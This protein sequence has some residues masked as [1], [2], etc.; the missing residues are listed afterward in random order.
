M[1]LKEII[2]EHL[3]LVD[4]DYKP[5]ISFIEQDSNTRDFYYRLASNEIPCTL[6]SYLTSKG[7]LYKIIHG[8]VKG[9][10]NAHN[11]LTISNMGSLTRRIVQAIK[12]EE[13]NI[14]NS[15]K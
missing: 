10:I 8:S 12:N 13:R 9:F 15:H 7:N 14:T 3:Y 6:G 4:N 2:A 5:E 11:E 1:K